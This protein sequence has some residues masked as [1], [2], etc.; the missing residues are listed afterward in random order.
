MKKLAL[1]MMLIGI[2]YAQTG[3]RVESRSQG[4]PGGPE[5]QGYLSG[6]SLACYSGWKTRVG[7]H[8]PASG[9]LRYDADMLCDERFDTC[10]AVDP[11]ST[12][13]W[14]ELTVIGRGPKDT[15]SWLR[16]VTVVNGYTKTEQLWTKNSR[17]REVRLTADGTTMGTTI[18]KDQPGVQ[19]ILF[20]AVKVG[21]GSK[22]RLEVLSSYPGT[23]YPDI[24][25]SEV[26]L[27]GAH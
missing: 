24:C 8:L 13:K 19:E 17:A 7:D 14:I 9:R 5:D 16:G 4:F 27:E 10:W 3:L 22:V 21:P 25:V 1:I 18:L 12:N 2:A 11:R 15:G 20:E 6:C 23:A 26:V